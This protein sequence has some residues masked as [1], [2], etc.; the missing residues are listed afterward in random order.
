MRLVAS[1]RFGPL[2]NEVGRGLD[3]KPRAEDLDVTLPRASQSKL[4]P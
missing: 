4:L 2:K 1:A 3:W